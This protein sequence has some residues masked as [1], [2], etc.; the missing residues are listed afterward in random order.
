MLCGTM[1]KADRKRLFVSALLGVCL[2]MVF[3]FRYVMPKIQSTSFWARNLERVQQWLGGYGLVW[4]LIGVLLAAFAYITLTNMAR[5]KEPFRV[6]LGIISVVF[7][8]LNVFGLLMYHLDDLP[9]FEFASWGLATVCLI[10]GWATLFYLLAYWFLRGLDSIHTPS[11][12]GKERPNWFVSLFENHP[13]R[14]SFCVILLCWFPWVAAYYPA[15]MDWD[16]YRQL[17]SALSLGKFARS[18]HDPFFASY[19]L[20]VFYRIGVKL[21]SENLGIFLFVLLRDLVMAG[22]Y[23]CCV[24][25]MR[26]AEL[27]TGVCLLVLAFFAVT[28]VWG[29]YAKHAFK[30]SL[31]AATF[32]AYVISLV[33]LVLR[34]RKQ[35]V[36]WGDCISGC[37]ITAATALLRNNPIYAI[38]PATGL[39]VVYLLCKKVHFLKCA[40]L[41]LGVLI[42]F[43]FNHYI[44]TYGNVTPGSQKE[45][46]SLFFQQTARTVKYHG[47]EITPEEKESIHAYLDYNTMAQLYDPVLSD[48]IKDRC[49]EDKNGEDAKKNY[50][51]AWASM[52]FKYPDTYIE[53]AVGGSYGYYAFTPKL[54][55][56]AG[57]QNSGMTIFNWIRVNW[58]IEKHGFDFHYIE[59]LEPAREALHAWARIWENIPVLSLTNSIASYTWAAVLIGYHFLRKKRYDALIPVLA[60]GIM[61]LT[62]VASPVNDSFRYY[63][64]AAAAVPALLPLLGRKEKPASADNTQPTDAAE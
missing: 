16:V 60:I 21:G 64:P 38:V 57:N 20:T 9:F 12:Q 51:K 46:L 40:T 31:A 29:A 39:L 23:A 28:P 32:C 6:G 59:P 41:L 17:C 44:F 19:V 56:G 2:S 42:Y 26:K 13:W 36:T 58:F 14:V 43:A 35:A 11:R 5:K 15:S 27:R 47:D 52:F 61:A 53:S 49:K 63:S 55:D 33:T 18:N 10:A 62:C 48:P 45:A 37:I 7:S 8:T 25:Q 34:A 54:P 4:S 50:F 3:S 30:D 22:I 1:E 24:H